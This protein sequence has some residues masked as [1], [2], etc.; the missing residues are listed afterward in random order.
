[1]LERAVAM[2][3]RHDGGTHPSI[4]TLRMSLAGSYARMG[5]GEDALAVL[6]AV[7][8]WLDTQ[9]DN[10]SL[11]AM[12]HTGRSRALLS[13]GHLRAARAALAEAEATYAAMGVSGEQFNAWLESLRSDLEAAERQQASR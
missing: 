10:P 12:L 11:R 9:G 7:Q 8:E 3:V 4:M 6:A 5:R 2:A 13:M 1:V